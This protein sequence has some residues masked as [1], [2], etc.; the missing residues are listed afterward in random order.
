MSCQI[1][2]GKSGSGYTE[3]CGLPTL[4]VCGDC[5]KEIC[6]GCMHMCC[7]MAFCGSCEQ[8]HIGLVHQGQRPPKPKGLFERLAG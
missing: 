1:E 5:G 3:P 7:A 4:T 6:L 2:F 8:E